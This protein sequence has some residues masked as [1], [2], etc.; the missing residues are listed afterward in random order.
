[1]TTK[2]SVPRSFLLQQDYSIAQ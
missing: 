1:M 2:Q